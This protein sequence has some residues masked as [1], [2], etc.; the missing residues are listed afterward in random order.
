MEEER[1]EKTSNLIKSILDTAQELKEKN[2]LDLEKMYDIVQERFTKL[3]E[4][5]LRILSGTLYQYL[6]TYIAKK[7]L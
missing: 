6:D 4:N 2:E 7:K 1:G 5:E 3:N